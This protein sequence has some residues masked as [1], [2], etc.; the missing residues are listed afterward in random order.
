MVT[1]INKNHLFLSQFH[2][3]LA[4]W[5][6]TLK[7]KTVSHSFIWSCVNSSLGVRTPDVRSWACPSSVSGCGHGCGAWCKASGMGRHPTDSVRWTFHFQATHAA[8]LATW[9][10]RPRRMVGGAENWVFVLFY[11]TDLFYRFKCNSTAMASGSLIGMSSPNGCFLQ[12]SWSPHHADAE[13]QA[14]ARS[15][16]ASPPF[17]SPTRVHP[18][19]PQKCCWLRASL[20]KTVIREIG[21][22]QKRKRSVINT[23][24]YLSTIKCEHTSS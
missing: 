12:K 19:G 24:L 18:A 3:Y 14:Q 5:F 7:K 10:I 11:F 1:A 20:S 23:R 17:P 8:P 22:V 15:G 13:W 21:K 16:P 9:G 4:N 6:S 2:I